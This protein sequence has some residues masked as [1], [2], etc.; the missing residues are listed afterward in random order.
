M[1]QF[2]KQEKV[3]DAFMSAIRAT[4]E[5]LDVLNA[6]IDDH[7]DEAVLASI[8][9][10]MSDC[11]MK[12]IPCFFAK[13]YNHIFRLTGRDKNHARKKKNYGIIQRGISKRDF[14]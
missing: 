9:R 2:V 12:I 6:Y 14:R 5:R 8:M 3:V 1:D 4:K 11:R 10:K 7:V 13:I